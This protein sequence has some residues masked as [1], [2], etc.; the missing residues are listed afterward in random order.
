MRK[1]EM[2]Q[3]VATP[4]QRLFGWLATIVMG[5]AAIT[6]IVLAL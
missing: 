3:F 1:Q 2:G 5:A 4:S 6:M